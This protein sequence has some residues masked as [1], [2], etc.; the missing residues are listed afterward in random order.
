[1]RSG[2]LDARPGP[3]D[4][5]GTSN[6]D[7]VLTEFAVLRW[8]AARA[9]VI[10]YWLTEPD[11]KDSID[12]VKKLRLQAQP[13]LARLRQVALRK[14]AEEQ[15]RRAQTMATVPVDELE[16]RGPVP[17]PPP[18]TGI[19][20]IMIETKRRQGIINA[21]GGQGNRVVLHKEFSEDPNEPGFE[22]NYEPLDHPEFND[23]QVEPVEI[24]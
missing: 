9:G 6:L 7:G 11:Q 13:E 21:G 24:P 23:L 12:A 22:P 16:F 5:R 1:L 15:Q 4:R 2:G 14:D 19:L 17:L 10:E 18:P 8:K 3:I 20:D